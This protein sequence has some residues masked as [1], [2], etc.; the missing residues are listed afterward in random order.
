MGMAT[1]PSIIYLYLHA[2]DSETFI[3][4]LVPIVAY[5]SGFFTYASFLVNDELVGAT[6]SDLDFIA[7]TR[8]FD[9]KQLIQLNTI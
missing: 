7:A 1:I 9:G 3:P 4:A 6:V 5:F 8:K 2:H